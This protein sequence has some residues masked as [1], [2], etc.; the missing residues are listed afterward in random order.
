[1]AS[2]V[3][4]YSHE[5]LRR[6]QQ[7]DAEIGP[8]IIWKEDNTE[9]PALDTVVVHSP[10]TRCLWLCWDMLHIRDGV[11]YKLSKGNFRLVTPRSLRKEVK[12]ARLCIVPQRV[13]ICG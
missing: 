7:E 12:V 8:V 13:D 10:A 2:G 3:S 1:M 9:R 4:G 11:L 5:D 6:L